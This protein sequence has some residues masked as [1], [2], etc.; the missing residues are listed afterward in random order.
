MFSYRNVKKSNTRQ[1][2]VE[3]VYLVHVENKT[4]P[5]LRMDT[6]CGTLLGENNYRDNVFFCCTVHFDICRVHSPTNALLLI[7]TTH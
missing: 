6:K 2:N 3:N 4:T 5:L 7:S 1:K